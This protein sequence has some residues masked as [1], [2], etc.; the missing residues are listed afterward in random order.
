MDFPSISQFYSHRCRSD[1]DLYIYKPFRCELCDEYFESHATLGTHLCEGILDA[2]S[3]GDLSDEEP[4]L[5]HPVLLS[6]KFPVQVSKFPRRSMSQDFHESDTVYTEDALWVPFCGTS[7]IGNILYNC[8]QCTESF[9][10]EESL[11][12]HIVN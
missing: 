12:R 10:L 3:D 11:A 6:Q 7:S 1:N 2:V 4:F 9:L 5:S 8:N